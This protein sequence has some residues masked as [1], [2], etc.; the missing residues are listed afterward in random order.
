MFLNLNNLYCVCVYNIDNSNHA[1]FTFIS[2][3]HDKVMMHF[4]T[5]MCALV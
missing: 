1:P 2:G 3:Y 4:A 5:R